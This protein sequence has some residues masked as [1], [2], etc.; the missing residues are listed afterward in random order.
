VPSK[1]PIR[2][3]L[4][5]TASVQISS[6]STIDTQTGVLACMDR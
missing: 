2:D 1:T 5:E 3:F 6:Q 4:V